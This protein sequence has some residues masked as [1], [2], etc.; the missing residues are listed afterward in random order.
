M[1]RLPQPLSRRACLLGLGVAAAAPAAGAAS[2][3]QSRVTLPEPELGGNVETV[4]EGSR[5]QPDGSIVVFGHVRVWTAS[6]VLVHTVLKVDGRPRARFAIDLPRVGEWEP[7]SFEAP[8]GA[9]R[10]EWDATTTLSGGEP[11]AEDRAWLIAKLDERVE[12][13]R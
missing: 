9:R 5:P 13:D 10:L 4:F 1:H 2:L 12:R 11:S 6:A 7:I 8:P 3:S